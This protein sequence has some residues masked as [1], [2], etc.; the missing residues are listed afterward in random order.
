[1]VELPRAWF[2]PIIDVPPRGFP[3]GIGVDPPGTM[4]PKLVP[5][6]KPSGP[7]VLIKGKPPHCENFPPRDVPLEK[8]VL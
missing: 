4:F 1:M 2:L 7:D 3:P 8:G 5:G 6:K